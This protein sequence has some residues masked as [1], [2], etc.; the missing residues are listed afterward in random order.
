MKREHRL[1]N[2]GESIRLRDCEKKSAVNANSPRPG[3]PRPIG[4]PVILRLMRTA[5]STGRRRFPSRWP[6]IVAVVHLLFLALAFVACA[7]IGNRG[8]AAPEW[9]GPFFFL[10]MADVQMGY[11]ADNKDMVREIETLDKAVAA[12][13]RLQPAFVVFCGD[14]VNKSGDEAQIAEFRRLVGKLDKSIPAHYVVGN[15]DVTNQPK[16]TDVAAYRGHFGP[17]YYSFDANG[18]HFV[19]L[20]SSLIRT[21]A[22]LADEDKAQWSWLPKDLADSAAAAPRHTV[23]FSHHPPFLKTPG[24]A[25]GYD[26]LPTARRAELLDLCRRYHVGNVFSGHLHYCLTAKTDGLEIYAAG[27]VSKPLR[28]D[29]SGFTIVKVYGDRIEHEYVDINQVPASVTFEQ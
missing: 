2:A 11:A 1:L 15:H 10:V 14:Q 9:R 19:V 20:D 27:C 24:E 4:D 21:A 6:R 7:P 25:A 29:P 3:A 18:C 28:T 13:N 26:N 23:L 16:L 22:T 17:D 8:T 5:R 12:A